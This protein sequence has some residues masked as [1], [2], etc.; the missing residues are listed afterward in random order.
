MFGYTLSNK[1]VDNGYELQAVEPGFPAE[2]AGIRKGDI[3]VSING[4]LT[5][6]IPKKENLDNRFF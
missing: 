2:L 4:Q 3:M 5:K 1:K 6:K